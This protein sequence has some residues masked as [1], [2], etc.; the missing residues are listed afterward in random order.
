[1][2]ER[3]ALKRTEPSAPAR[4]LSAQGL[5]QQPALDFGSGYGKDADTYGMDAYDPHHGPA[6]LPEKA[7]N[8]VL[9]TYVLNTL[10]DQERRGVLARA[11]QRLSDE[12]KLYATVR[13]DAKNLKGPTSI[14]TYQEL[15]DMNEPVVARGSGFRTYELA[16]QANAP[17]N[18]TDE[19][20]DAAYQA[21]YPRAAEFMKTNPKFKIPGNESALPIPDVYNY[22]IRQEMMKELSKGTKV[23]ADKLKGGLAD[24]KSDKKYDKE[25]LAKGTKVEK[26]EHTVSTGIAKEIA[27][28]HLEEGDKYYDHLE[29]MEENME[30]K[31][32]FYEPDYIAGSET[33]AATGERRA[34]ATERLVQEVLMRQNSLAS[35]DLQK[36]LDGECDPC[37]CEPVSGASIK[38]KVGRKTQEPLPKIAQAWVPPGDISPE[39]YTRAA[40]PQASPILRGVG[41]GL[42]GGALLAPMGLGAAGL[43][44][45]AGA[46]ILSGLYKNR[47]IGDARRELAQQYQQQR[48]EQRIVNQMMMDRLLGVQQQYPA[49]AT[50]WPND[51]TINGHPAS[52]ITDQPMRPM[53]QA[54]VNAARAQGVDDTSKIDHGKLSPEEEAKITGKDSPDL[55]KTSSEIFKEAKCGGKKNKEVYKA[56]KR[57]HPEYSD[58]KK[59]RIANTVAKSAEEIDALNSSLLLSIASLI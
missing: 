42:L 5:I 40:A 33:D 12:G 52:D 18:W 26:D 25:Q 24:N 6:D 14:G 46:G 30:K 17:V 23:A 36:L 1:M 15:V 45:G 43:P 47:Q 35:S 3:T 57:D 44:I 53:D 41:G 9:L 37:A 22:L 32:A 19:Q 49:V 10:R 54:T 31:V 56:L 13:T 4:T 8:T 7:Y 11:M 16:K 58:E 59:A 27:K 50:M 51:I 20:L 29:E 34:S 55:K 28:D 38:S 21:A 48:A 39:L 2:V